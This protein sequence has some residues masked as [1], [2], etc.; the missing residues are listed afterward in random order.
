MKQALLVSL[1]LLPVAAVA[2]VAQPGPSA[3]PEMVLIPRSV[4]ETAANWIAQPDAAVAV[5]LYAAFSACIADNPAGGV[6]TR[7][8]QDQCSIVSEAIDARDKELAALHA[9][10]AELQTKLDA[11]SK[12][13]ASAPAVTP[14]SSDKKN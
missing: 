6:M 2:Q 4:A 12:K 5:K 11:E 8:G 13:I 7:S 14:P 10:V 3:K 9:K 1:L